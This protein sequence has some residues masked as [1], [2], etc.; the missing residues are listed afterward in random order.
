[1]WVVSLEYLNRDGGE[2]RSPQWICC[3]CAEVALQFMDKISSDVDYWEQYEEPSAIYLYKTTCM[4][5]DK[6]R[7]NVIIDGLSDEETYISMTHLEYRMR[8][9]RERA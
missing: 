2:F 7:D 3:S 1:M 8:L 9:L 5:N 4:D 6:L